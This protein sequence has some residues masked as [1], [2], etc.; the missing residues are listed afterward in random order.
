MPEDLNIVLIMSDEH[1]GDF[2]GTGAKSD[3]ATPSLDAL[4]ER[5]MNFEKAYCTSPLCMPTRAALLSGKYPSTIGCHFTEVVLDKCYTLAEHLAQ[6]GWHTCSIGKMHLFGETAEQ[7]FGFRERRMRYLYQ[8]HDDYAAVAGEEVCQAYLGVHKAFDKRCYNHTLSG[9]EIPLEMHFDTLVA[10]EAVDFFNRNKD[11]RF[12]VEIGIEK[13]HPVWFPPTE[14]IERVDPA[15]ML[16]PERWQEPS[17]DVPTRRIVWQNKFLNMGWTEEEAKN[18]MA[19]YT[20]SVTYIDWAIGRI[21]KGLEDAGLAEKTLVIFTADHGES[22]FDHGML[23]KHCGLEGAI[24]IPFIAAGPGVK[25]GET[26]TDGLAEITDLFP[27]FCEYLDVP[28]PGGL[29]GESLVPTFGG[30][31]PPK[32]EIAIAEYF[33]PGHN[34]EGYSPERIARS[35][36]WKY[37]DNDGQGDELYDETA[38]PGEF[39]NLVDLPEYADK[40]EEMK[41]KLAARVDAWD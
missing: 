19:A 2:L 11:R 27:T 21:L 9:S 15:R 17:Q 1:R 31:E 23:Q 4:I 41:V 28:M 22:L 18:A 6:H 34:E 16:L 3:L 14:F 38:D 26:C 24:R 20:A 33:H 30:D 8:T 5:G 29:H 37:I 35:L 39:N 25:Q 40:L 36:D 7:L 10:N 32:K 12:F 13:P